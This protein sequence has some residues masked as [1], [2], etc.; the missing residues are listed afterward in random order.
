M[1]VDKNSRGGLFNR[2]RSRENK[3]QVRRSMDSI[4]NNIDASMKALYSDTYLSDR[5]NLDNLSFISDKMEDNIN[6]I[7]KRNNKYDISNTSKLYTRLMVKNSSTENKNEAKLSSEIESLF[8][9][10]QFTDAILGSYLSNKWIADFDKEIDTILKMLPDLKEALDVLKDSILSAD[11]VSKEF[12]YPKVAISD[13]VEQKA[14]IDRITKLSEK[15]GLSNKVE[16]WYDNA[17]HYGEQFVY[18]VPYSKAIEKL[19]IVKKQTGNSNVSIPMVEHGIINES[20]LK[21]NSD[22]KAKI[23]GIK[24]DKK[25]N[26]EVYIDTSRMLTS[27]I[28]DSTVANRVYTNSP[29]SLTE[30]YHDDLKN[31]ISIH[32][33]TKF[34]RVIADDLDIPEGLNPRSYKGTGSKGDGSTSVDVRGCVIKSLD[35]HNLIRLYVDDICL[36]YYYLEF[37][38]KND[39]EMNYH[40]DSD[41]NLGYSKSISTIEKTITDNLQDTRVDHLMKLISKQMSDKLDATFVNAN[42]DLTKEIYAILKYNDVFNSNVSVR[43]SF[44]PPEDVKWLRF[45]EDSDLH[46]GISDVND[47]LYPAKLLAMLYTTFVTGTLTRGQDKRVYYVKQTIETNIAQ[48]LLNVINQIKKSNFNMRSIENLNNLLN[49]TGRFNDYIIPVGPS[50]DSPIQFEIMPGQQFEINQDLFNMLQEMAINPIAPLEL[51]Q[52]RLNPEYATAY[53]TSSLKLLRKTYRRQARLE[54]FIS[55]IFTDAYA[56]EYGEYLDIDCELPP[57]VFLSMINTNQLLD[58][59]KT[60]VESLAELEYADDQSDTAEI[61]KAIFIR[62]MIRSILGTYIRP[63]EIEKH[64]EAAKFEAQRKK[65]S[66]PSE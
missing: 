47:S 44:L 24:L 22:E 59:T 14:V 56:A 66:E 12:I 60:Y 48:T 4:V 5:S 35:R 3:K 65:V 27:C 37:V 63:S 42:Q 15:Y 64:K 20:S 6:A 8:G 26:L 53:T 30:S 39:L 58:N 9:D 11:S 38:N 1:P 31:G 23:K 55:S 46:I 43:V 54:L 61:E 7:I 45:R 52:M 2:R 21:I 16:D 50:G 62:K 18:Q 19:L 32:E 33:K 49:I 29:K 57:P 25:C 13:N 40:M 34:D 41:R 51:V 10:T 28:E 36:G 17:S